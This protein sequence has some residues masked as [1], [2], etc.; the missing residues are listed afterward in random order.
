MMH[1]EVL[2]EV[3]KERQ[4]D[5]PKDWPCKGR[6][7]L[8]PLSPKGRSKR[9]DFLRDKSSVLTDGEG[10]INKFTFTGAIS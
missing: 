5:T 6:A 9:E 3:G 2:E 1:R 7:A 10:K 8:L 4:E